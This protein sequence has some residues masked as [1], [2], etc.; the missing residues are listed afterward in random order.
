MQ[1]WLNPP[2]CQCFVSPGLRMDININASSGEVNFD[3]AGRF[4]L[5]WKTPPYGS[6]RDTNNSLFRLRRFKIKLLCLA[7]KQL[8]FVFFKAANKAVRRVI[9][10]RK[11]GVRRDYSAKSRSWIRFICSQ[12]AACSSASYQEILQ[13]ER[14]ALILLTHRPVTV[15][16]TA[17][18]HTW[19][20]NFNSLKDATF[21]FFCDIFTAISENINPK[22]LV[23]S[24][25]ISPATRTS[26][27]L[28]NN[29][30]KDHRQSHRLYIK[31]GCSFRIWKVWTLW[32]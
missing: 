15:I 8:C 1:G 32:Q 21:V 30:S 14:V 3:A 31:D 13:T 7:M 12:H 6:S 25:I 27:K 4:V 9:R 17:L 16:I 22:F 28:Y 2:K 20:I 11:A 23:L 19:G 29:F 26:H 5:E 10:S 24:K 18:F